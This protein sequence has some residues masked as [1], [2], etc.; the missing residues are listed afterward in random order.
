M[1]AP[2]IFLSLQCGGMLSQKSYFAYKQSCAII[3]HSPRATM[4]E[5]KK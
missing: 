2:V 3:D 1:L 4:L 5:A